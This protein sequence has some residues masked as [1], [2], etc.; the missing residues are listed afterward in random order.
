MEILGGRFWILSG[1]KI[2]DYVPSLVPTYVG[3]VRTVFS[4]QAE[5]RNVSP[6]VEPFCGHLHNKRIIELCELPSTLESPWSPGPFKPLG[7]QRPPGAPG[8]LK[9]FALLWD[10]WDLWGSWDL[11]NFVTVIL[12]INWIANLFN[13]FCRRSFF[14]PFSTMSPLWMEVPL[15]FSNN[16]F[17]SRFLIFWYIDFFYI[18]LGIPNWSG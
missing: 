13:D 17:D 7:L 14:V 16:N 2:E 18:P 15:A 9:P 3:E 10:P 8:L 11:M 4:S 1:P 6:K 5:G 12:T